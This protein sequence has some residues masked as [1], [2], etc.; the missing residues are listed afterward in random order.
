MREK[1]GGY[2]N[3]A[4]I[5]GFQRAMALSK[6]PIGVPPIHFGVDRAAKFD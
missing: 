5:I 4:N 1:R 3:L 2:P 6:G